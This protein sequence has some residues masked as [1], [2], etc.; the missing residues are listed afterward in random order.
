MGV[1]QRAS[2]IVKLSMEPNGIVQAMQCTRLHT[3]NK[4]LLSSV[5]LSHKLM[6]WKLVKDKL[7]TE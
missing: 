7:V 3:R 1:C 2:P 4:I 5:Y 6:P